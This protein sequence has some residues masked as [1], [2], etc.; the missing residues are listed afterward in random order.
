MSYRPPMPDDSYLR[1]RSLIKGVE[2]HTGDVAVTKDM[3]AA[4]IIALNDSGILPWGV[5]ADEPLV[6]TEIFLAMLEKSSI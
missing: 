2:R 5:S 6:V 1:I 4:G 3:I